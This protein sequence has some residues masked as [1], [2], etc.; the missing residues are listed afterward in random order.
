[1]CNSLGCSFVT[2]QKVLQRRP[3]EVEVRYIGGCPYK[4]GKHKSNINTSLRA[5][6]G[7]KSTATIWIVDVKN[8]YGLVATNS[9]L[10]DAF[11]EVLFRD[12]LHNCLKNYELN[13]DDPGI[14]DF[15]RVDS[16]IYQCDATN[17][18]RSPIKAKLSSIPT[19][20]RHVLSP[21]SHRLLLNSNPTHSIT[22]DATFNIIQCLVPQMNIQANYIEI[23]TYKES[24]TVDTRNKKRVVIEC[25]KIVDEIDIYTNIQRKGLTS[26]LL[27]RTTDNLVKM[28][29]A[30]NKVKY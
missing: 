30:F 17:Q 16:N 19:D 21:I 6:I 22:I 10:D 24:L 12:D 23:G 13:V 20:Y 27:A 28:W 7:L 18:L 9:I 1:M 2:I 11:I 29:S 14:T 15:Y 8:K 5:L 25:C 26:Y 4:P 3:G